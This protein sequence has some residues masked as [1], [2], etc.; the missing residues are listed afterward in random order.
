MGVR[1]VRLTIAFDR[2]IGRKGVSRVSQDD[3][4][5]AIGCSYSTT[6]AG[7]RSARRAG[8]SACTARPTT[9]GSGGWSG[10]DTDPAPER[11]PSAATPESALDLRRAADRGLCAS[12]A[13]TASGD[14]CA[15]TGST[16]AP[17]ACRSSPGMRAVRA[18]AAATPPGAETR[19]SPA[20]FRRP[21]GGRLAARARPHRQRGEF[22]SSNAPAAHAGEVVCGATGVMSSPLRLGLGC[23][24]AVRRSRPRDRATPQTAAPRPPGLRS[25]R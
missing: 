18:A 22:R 6:P 3:E 21:A 19:S 7:P 16:R 20:A 12:S 23:R 4:L 9:P 13:I 15:G 1:C 11:A 5:L 14:A 17:S 8:R 10:T 24:R 25:G 2:Q